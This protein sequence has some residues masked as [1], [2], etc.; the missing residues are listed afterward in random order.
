MA[1]QDFLA[2]NG[3]TLYTDG[4]NATNISNRCVP[5]FNNNIEH[6][7]NRDS[8]INPMLNILVKSTLGD[9]L[10]VILTD[11]S[12]GN[13]STTTLIGTS[14]A[15]TQAIF[16]ANLSSNTNTAYANGN[17]CTIKYYEG[18]SLTVNKTIKV[19]PVC[20]PKYT[21]VVCEFIN[22]FGGW[23]VL[24]FFKAQSNSISVSG[25]SY[26]LL[27]DGVAYNPSLPQTSTFNIN[28]R[29]TVTLNT[30]WVPQSYSELIQDLL[31]AE[32]ILLD[33]KPVDV[34]SESSDLKTSLKDRNINYEI[35]FEYAYNLIN[36][37][38]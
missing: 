22:R 32:T 13:L 1:S 25:T 16:S 21:P 33:G 10:E 2:T 28:G 17:Y 30:G 14:T 29:Q 26:N 11:L 9:K 23:Q 37:V 27:A 4:V 12:G 20:E 18:A 36:N 24:T 7:Y 3:Y 6:Y 38:V 8:G 35:Q 19:T 31:L 15:A 5:L 34:K